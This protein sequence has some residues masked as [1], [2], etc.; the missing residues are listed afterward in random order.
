ML[1]NQYWVGLDIGEAMT[2]ICVT[3]DAGAVV[4]ENACESTLRAVDAVL[5]RFPK[6]QIGLVGLESGIGSNLTRKLKNLGYPVGAFEARKASKFLAIRRNKTDPGDAAGLAQLARL[7]RATVSQVHTKT[8]E[9]QLL[10]SKL[11]MRRLLIKLRLSLESS[12]RSRVRSYGAYVKFAR[13]P[14]DLR[15]AIHDANLQILADDGIDI[16]AEIC[17]LIDLWEAVRAYLKQLDKALLLE[18]KAHPICKNL[19]SVPGVGPICALS[20]YSAVE[21]PSRFRRASE[22]ASYLGLTPRIYQ[23]GKAFSTRGISKMGNKMTRSSLV[24][25]ATVMLCVSKKESALRT[26]GLS[27]VERI[28]RRRAAVAV[29]RKLSVVMLSMWRSGSEFRANTP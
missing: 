17:P 22:V 10:Q 11:S 2:A 29:A 23:S 1:Q 26:W 20:F 12:V 6:D 21:D 8:L 5:D 14:V 18:A 4:L 7:G 28:G 15:Q 16:A 25:A 13:K 9:T 3:D 27:L 19:M 24:T